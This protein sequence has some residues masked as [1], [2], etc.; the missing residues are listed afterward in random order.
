VTSLRLV[1]LID[2]IAGGGAERFVVEL[3]AGLAARGVDVTLC[4]SRS[5]PD[6]VAHARLVQAGVR[7]L[8]LGRMRRVQPRSWRPL[9]RQLRS[10]EADVLN[11]HLHSS[12][13]YGGLLSLAT[14]T[15]LVATEHGST[16]DASLTRRTLDRALVARRA[17][18]TV[19][20]S[21][22]TRERLLAR[23]YASKRVRVITPAPALP[24]A[25]MLSRAAARSALGL[26]AWSGPVIGSL[27]GLR[28]EKRLDVLVEAAALMAARRPVRFVV[29]G[30]GPEREALER[31]V[32]ERGMRDVVV[33]AGWREDARAL[34]PAFDAFA[35][36]S[37]TEGTPLALIEAMLAGVPIVAT[38]VGG[39][40]ALAP[41]GECALLVAPGDAR[42]LS[43]GLQRLLD[44]PGLAARLAE[45]AERRARSQ[46]SL[47]R[48]VS[49]W[50]ELL[51]EARNGR[52][53]GAGS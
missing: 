44:E 43:D 9:F 52:P 48:A 34:L 6:P 19:A 31:L 39:V 49:A 26:A 29:L 45:R 2:R 28:A 23:G 15:R 40:P 53:A 8:A 4:V 16:A 7:V 41:S 21:E 24:S 18:A 20:V 35:L 36:A 1:M 27:C 46:H 50:H 12:N 33:F 11:T 17:W 51:V 38:G 22:H 47:E 32:L 25:R 10:G 37:D 30:D 13:V 42:G 14:G 5:D 3:A